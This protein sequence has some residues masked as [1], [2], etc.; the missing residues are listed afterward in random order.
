M[1]IMNDPMSALR[2]LDAAAG[3]GATV[4]P[5]PTQGSNQIGPGGGTR[6]GGGSSPGSGPDPGRAVRCQS[7]QED[8]LEAR[9]DARAYCAATFL[10]AVDPDCSQEAQE[11][12]FD[13][14]DREIQAQNRIL[15]EMREIGCAIQ[16]Q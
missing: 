1:A 11:L 5:R 12:L 13:G 10:C 3:I 15:K 9:G 2:V 8:L 6:P 16:S 4:A 14:C 7:L